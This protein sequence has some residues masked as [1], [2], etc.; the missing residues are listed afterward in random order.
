M[1]KIDYKT[2]YETLNMAYEM[3][4]DEITKLQNNKMSINE[5]RSL[6]GLPPI[7]TALIKVNPKD[8]VKELDH[9]NMD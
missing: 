4:L 7:E 8:K 2:A 6:H 5:I 3:L 9:L 1:K